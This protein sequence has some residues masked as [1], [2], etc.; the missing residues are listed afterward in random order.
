MFCMRF[1]SGM[2]GEK[3]GQEY[4]VSITISKKVQEIP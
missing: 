4:F 3:N 1:M 2:F